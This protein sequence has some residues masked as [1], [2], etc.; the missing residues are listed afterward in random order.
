MHGA[1]LKCLKTAIR[2]R[3]T[4]RQS[5][6]DSTFRSYCPLWPETPRYLT[7]T[8]FWLKLRW[9][10]HEIAERPVQ[11]GLNV[12]AQLERVFI[13]VAMSIHDCFPFSYPKF[14]KHPKPQANSGRACPQISNIIPRKFDT[15]VTI[16]PFSPTFCDDLQS[17]ILH[18][19]GNSGPVIS[20]NTFLM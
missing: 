5:P 12:Q 18:L 14:F 7:S 3:A 4:T 8:R 19:G 15:V 13:L 1:E 16:M 2:A 20:A 17:Q 11:S 10:F 6:G 9:A